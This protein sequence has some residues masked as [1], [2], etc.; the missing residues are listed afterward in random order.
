MPEIHAFRGLRFDL[1]RVGALS[2]VI[3][4]PY[5]VVDGELDREL[6]AMSPYN[7]I[8]VELSKTD[9]SGAEGAQR[10]AS[11]AKHWSD[12]RRDGVV[13]QEPHPA[14]YLYEQEFELEGRT[15][16]RRG[17][18][19][20]V[21]LERFGAGGIFP[22]EQ[23]LAGPKADRLALYHATG[24]N[25]SPVFGL[26]PDTDQEVLSR[27]EAGRT[28]LTPHEAVDHLGVVHRMWPI[29]DS[30]THT[31]VQGAFADRPIFIADG[32]HR[33]ETG[34]RYR[35]E[36]AARGELKDEHD[37][38]NFVMMMLVSMSDPGL[39]ILP[40]HRLVSGLA[41]LDS[42]Q[43]AERLEGEFDIEIMPRSADGASAGWEWIESAGS[44]ECLAFGT[45][46]DGRWMTARLRSDATMDRLASE[47]SVEWRAL[48]VSILHELVL[49]HLLGD[50]GAIS[51][52][53]VHRLDEVRAGLADRRC[54][55]ACLVPPA[56]IG[57][58]RSI[59]SG[60]ETMPPKSTYFY[61]KLATG[62]VVN[63]LR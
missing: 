9:A 15:L 45:L 46:A 24:C 21:R 28:D 40:T 18:F 4:P 6:R 44:Q 8:R 1:S 13:F 63:P 5:D 12:W 60:G 57:D 11:A 17:F 37:A 29:T 27:L 58:V 59:A 26:Y 36:L 53:Y 35:D 31:L 2:S 51:C 20:R 22:H 23:T 54:D 33:Y 56:K 34:L 25:M 48:G 10:Y 50:M 14:F 43:L 49:K 47:R 55:L 7:I 39:V 3:A 41:S 30:R 32:H 19:A 52:R 38:A 61:P 16:R 62:L 42:V